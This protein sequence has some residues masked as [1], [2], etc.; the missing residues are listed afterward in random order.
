[1]IQEEKH[2]Q[3]RRTPEK[4]FF[5]LYFEKDC[6]AATLSGVLSNARY[7][8]K[9]FNPRSGKWVDAGVLAA[10]ASGEIALPNFP[11]N[12]AKSPTDWGLKLKSVS[13]R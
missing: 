2:F 10:N 6:P 5:L 9:W 12:L 8:A 11:G 1:M 4:D 7:G 13:A 3:N